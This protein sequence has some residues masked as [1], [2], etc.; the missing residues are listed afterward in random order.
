MSSIEFSESAN[1]GLGTVEV[2][3]PISM[4]TGQIIILFVSSRIF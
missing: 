4:Y 3:L 1:K 2:P